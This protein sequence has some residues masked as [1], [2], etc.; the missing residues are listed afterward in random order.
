MAFKKEVFGTTK[1]GKQ[2]SLYTVENKNGVVAKYTDFGAILVSLYVPD[3][4]RRR[5]TWL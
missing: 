3:K 4:I 5:S 1:D 2:A